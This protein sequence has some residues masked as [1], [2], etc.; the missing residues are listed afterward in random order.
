MKIEPQRK[1]DYSMMEAL[2]SLKLY[3]LLL[4]SLLSL[5]YGFA[6]ANNY[7]TYGLLK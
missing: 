1:V 6:I 5:T 7:K 4:M 3:K 2:K